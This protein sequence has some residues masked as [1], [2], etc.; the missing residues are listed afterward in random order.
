MTNCSGKKRNF[1]ELAERL[2][3]IRRRPPRPEFVER[4]NE[5]MKRSER[6]LKQNAAQ[7]SD[8]NARQRRG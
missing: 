3:E 2:K 1:R 5:L 8:P 6:E 7:L 4:F